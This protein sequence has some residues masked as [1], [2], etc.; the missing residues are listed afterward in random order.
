MN[1]V[2]DQC[3]REVTWGAQ[4]YPLNLNSKWVRNVL[5]YRGLPGP[6]GISSPADCLSRFESGNYSIEE[7]ERILELGL[8]GAGMNEQETDQLIEAHVRR[9]PIANNAG[10]AAGLLVALFVG[11]QS[12]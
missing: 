11:N 8:I 1:D 2:I 5:S 7:V 3:A 10:V 4:T 12:S 6:N 9:Q